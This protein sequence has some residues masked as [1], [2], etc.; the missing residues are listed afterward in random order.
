MAITMHIRCN[1]SAFP[2]LCLNTFP[3]AAG[4]EL[5]VSSYLW[6]RIRPTYIQTKIPPHI[7]SCNRENFGSH[8]CT[9]TVQ[10][11]KNLSPALASLR[12]FTET[13]HCSLVATSVVLSKCKLT[14]FSTLT[15]STSFCT[16]IVPHSLII[17]FCV[18][19]LN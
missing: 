12:Y 15:S 13:D 5:I 6:P 19:Q 16:T 2:R 7:H 17:S 1:W 8:V 14:I 4:D 11:A 9:I 10:N 3:L 18:C